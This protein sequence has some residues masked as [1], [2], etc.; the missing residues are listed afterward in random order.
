MQNKNIFCVNITSNA[1]V[2]LLI[3]DTITHTHNPNYYVS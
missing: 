3:P 2:L 1:F